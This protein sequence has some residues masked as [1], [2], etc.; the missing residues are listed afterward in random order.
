VTVSMLPKNTRRFHFMR[1]LATGGFGSVY[2]AK[3]VNDDGFS[4]LIAVKL[5]HQEWSEED[6]IASRMRDEARLLGRLRHRNILNVIDLTSI[7]GRC[8][9]L[10]E[11]VEGVDLR[12]LVR[13]LTSLNQR[14]PL[15]VVLEV[16]AAVADALDAAYYHAPY[17]GERPLKVIHRDIKPSNIMM[18]AAGD[19]RVL[20][21]GIASADFESRE[22]QTRDLTFGSIE[23]MAPERLFYEP[24]SPKSDIYS[25]GATLVELLAGTGLGKAKVKEDV[26]SAFIAQRLD[27]LFALERADWP[28]QQQELRACLESLLAYGDAVRPNAAALVKQLREFVRHGSGPSLTEWAKSAVPVFV[29]DSRTDPEGL[30]NALVGKTLLEDGISALVEQAQATSKPDSWGLKTGQ[31][32]VTGSMTPAVRKEKM[33]TDERVVT[34]H[35]LDGW[36]A[37]EP[38]RISTTHVFVLSFGVTVLIV[39][40]VAMIYMWGQLS[41]S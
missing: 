39:G 38:K 23:Y 3:V 35:D 21:F 19:V 4:R 7:D 30:K 10:M 20:D 37:E 28:P 33:F 8:A 27:S 6:E 25:L 26:H 13:E 14:I 9:I 12:T 31:R 17:P 24:S 2:L 41:A 36:V 15:S 16:G 11:F 29:E 34:R 22:S 5:L 1:Q 40:L 18:D 32:G